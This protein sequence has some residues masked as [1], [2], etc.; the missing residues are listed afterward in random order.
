MEKIVGEGD[1]IKNPSNYR[2]KIVNMIKSNNDIK[3]NGV[4]GTP[5]AECSGS[6][7]PGQLPIVQVGA[8]RDSATD[9]GFGI[10]QASPVLVEQENVTGSN[11]FSGDQANPLKATGIDKDNQKWNTVNRKRKPNKPGKSYR[12]LKKLQEFDSLFRTNEPYFNK[13]FDIKFPGCNLMED[14]SAIKLDREIRE[15]LGEVKIRKSGR[16]GL[17]IEV[18]NRTQASK[19][20]TIKEIADQPVVIYKHKKFNQV[21]GV[22]RAK[23]LKHD[24]EDEIKEHLKSQDVDEVRRVTIKKNGEIIKTDVYILTFNLLICPKTIKIADWLIIKVDEYNYTPQQCYNCLKYG[25]ISKYCKNQEKTCFKCSRKGHDK[26]SCT[27]DIRCLHCKEGHYSNN[28]SCPRY[29]CEIKIINTQMKEKIPKPEA[30]ERVLG[31]CPQYETLFFSQEPTTEEEIPVPSQQTTP[32]SADT[33]D[34]ADASS[35]MDVVSDNNN[36]SIRSEKPPTSP[37][38]QKTNKRNQS[39]NSKVQS[40]IEP[41]PK[42]NKTK[43]KPT[44]GTNDPTPSKSTYKKPSP[45][46]D[47]KIINQHKSVVEYE[48][49]EDETTDEPSQAREMNK[50]PL[51]PTVKT[52]TTK[53]TNTRKST[54]NLQRIPTLGYRNKNSNRKS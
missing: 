2:V 3:A 5:S 53:R 30:I 24:S 45:E 38:P 39:P 13:F 50:R 49:S 16:N 4:N 46:P 52:T 8:V 12:E 18:K 28:K 10:V 17:F 48:A 47:K 32:E 15:E 34:V 22:I 44:K 7:A 36:N 33:S 19:I 37:K 42:I 43:A 21:K 23:C 41:N 25:H 20:E 26:D 40:K 35:D 11:G 31:L 14:V 9:P 54:E 51:S 1:P 6:V 27:F 29:Q